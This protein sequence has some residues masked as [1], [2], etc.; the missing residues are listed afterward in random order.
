MKRRTGIL[1]ALLCVAASSLPA[2]AQA[3]TV[4]I[5]FITTLSGPAGYL[6]QDARDGF[7]LAV[8]EG[9]G[10]LGGVPVDVMVQDDGLKPIQGRLTADRFLKDEHVRLFTGTI[11]SN[12]A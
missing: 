6:G 2:Q 1:A 5:G 7:M 12:V 4:K 11:F 8:K 10:K 9:G 3:P